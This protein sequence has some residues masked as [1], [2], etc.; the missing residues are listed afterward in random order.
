MPLNMMT[1]TKMPLSM[2]TYTIMPLNMM[3]DTKMPLSMITYTDN[4]SQ[5]DDRH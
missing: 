4:A 5:Y 2:I 3:T 1:D